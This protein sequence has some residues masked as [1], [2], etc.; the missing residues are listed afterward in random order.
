M[1]IVT[2]YAALKKVDRLSQFVVLLYYV[3]MFWGQ[4]FLMLL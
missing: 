2:E 1:F 3:Y 4:D